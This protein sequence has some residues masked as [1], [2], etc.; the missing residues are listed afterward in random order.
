VQLKLNSLSLKSFS[1]VNSGMFEVS[2]GS[3]LCLFRCVIVLDNVTATLDMI[4]RRAV[5]NRVV[6]AACTADRH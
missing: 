5:V 6:V 1:Y 3:Y 2:E 4:Q